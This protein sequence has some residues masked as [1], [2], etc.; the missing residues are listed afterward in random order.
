MYIPPTPSTPRRRRLQRSLKHSNHNLLWTMMLSIS[1]ILFAH[2]PSTLAQASPT[3]ITVYTAQG[4]ISAPAPSGTY[5][6]LPAYDPTILTAPG[7][8]QPPINSVA[9][10]LPATAADAQGANM[11]LS[12]PQQGNFLG[13]SIE[14]S[15]APDVLGK[16]SKL[17]SP[18]FLNYMANIQVRAG[19]GP[20]IRV[21]GNTQDS[22]SIY[23]QGFPNG[24]DMQKIKQIDAV[25]NTVSTIDP[26]DPRDQSLTQTLCRSTLPS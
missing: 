17:L 14:L 5:T 1:L 11:T 8:P 21:G 24:T 25:A 20:I 7:P 3:T 15:V 22:S 10:A 4:T 9:V 13:F 2:I 12:K 23:P 16:S 19:Q 26:M 6:G 18:V